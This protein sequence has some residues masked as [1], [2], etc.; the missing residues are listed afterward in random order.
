MANSRK[1]EFTG[2]LGETLAARLDFPEDGLIRGYAIFAHCF[3]CSKNVRAA[4]FVSQALAD[5]GV[6]VLRFDFTGLG[7]SEGD[8]ANTN[9]SSNVEDLEKA[10]AWL[11][12]N[13][14][15]PSLLVGHSLGGTACLVAASRIESVRA[16]ATIGSPADAAHVVHSFADQV[17]MIEQDGI[18][19]VSLAGRPFQ[20]KKQFL[21][22]IGGQNVE[23]A[24]SKLRVAL[25]FCHSPLDEQVSID[26]AS[27]LFAAARHPKSFLSLDNAD[28]L[29][30]GEADAEYAAGVIAAWAARF[31][32]NADLE[33][34]IAEAEEGP[35]R[36]LAEETGKG[37]FQTRIT[38]GKHE[39]LADEPERIGG[40]DSGP[41]P[42]ELLVSALGAC[43]SMTVRMYAER[44]EWPLK[45]V[46]VSLHHQKDYADDCDGCVQ[47][48]P[49]KLDII[50]RELHLEGDLSAEQREKLLEIADKCPVHR[51]LNSPVIIRTRLAT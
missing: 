19:K 18:A 24:V 39:F 48:E 43:T 7:Q 15:A 4:H 1:V 28:H 40:L 20:I 13:E 34:E 47:G 3:S 44:K 2:A 6:A 12:E 27:R 32:L 49:R 14:G 16:V 21:E 42:Y 8:F 41:D 9:F 29:L 23:T 51:T 31:D 17:D 36:V 37:K 38:A 35:E 10:A 11:T 33:A 26:N 22:D 5:R 46:S 45:S 50:T 30:T 25:L